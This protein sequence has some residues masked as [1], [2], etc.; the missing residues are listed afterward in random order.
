MPNTLMTCALLSKAVYSKT[1]PDGM[2]FIGYEHIEHKGTDTFGIAYIT[3]DIVFIAF[4]G[5]ESRKDWLNDFKI[6][7]TMF[8]GVR[9]HRGFAECA[10]SVLNQ[11]SAILKG[12]PDHKVILTGHSL[13]A[14][15]AVLIAVALR[16]RPVQVINF[17]QPRV[18]TH[19]ELNLALYGE[20]VRVHNGSDVVPRSPWLGYSHAGTCLY[21][22]NNS[23][24]LTD[25]SEA[26]MFFDRLLTLSQR[27]TDHSM[28][29]Y[30]KELETC[31]P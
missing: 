12:L 11:V 28:T 29:G 8:F 13:G 4:A 18:S 27:A 24:R 17:G 21:L 30:I 9:A 15:I 3:E 23:K 31:E 25:P 22:T 10:G 2:N 7:K 6:I 1:V 26:R 20:Y 19:S 5:S 14:A 16:P